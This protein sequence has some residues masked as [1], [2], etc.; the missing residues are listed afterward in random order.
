MEENAVYAVAQWKVRAGNLGGVLQALRELAQSSRTEEG[1][2]LYEAHHAVDDNH[3]IILYEGYRSQAA[4]QA[5]R[6]SE[7]FQQLVLGI[8]VPLLEHRE[9]VPLAK[10]PL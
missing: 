9:V 5:H 6:E 3:V 2:I 1:N 8:I 10:L 7:H 4:L